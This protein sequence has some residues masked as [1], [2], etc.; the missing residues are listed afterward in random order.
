M[1]PTRWLSRLLVVSLV[2]L[3]VTSTLPAA[4][5]TDATRTGPQFASSAVLEERGDVASIAVRMEDGGSA[6]VDILGKGNSDYEA[7]LTLRDEDNDGRV[8]LEFNTYL[9]GRNGAFETA[10]EGDEVL[11]RGQ[12][13]ASGVLPV[14]SYRMLTDDRNDISDLE[15]EPRETA[16]VTALV[17]PDGA[18]ARLETGDDVARYRR[19]GNLTTRPA[20]DTVPVAERDTLVVRLKASGIAGA[21][22]AQEG[23]NVTERFRSLVASDLLSLDVDW[24]NTGT[25]VPDLPLL[26]NRSGVSVASRPGNDAYFVVVD[27]AA[28]KYRRGEVQTGLPAGAR[29][30]VNATVPAGSALAS[31]GRE[32]ATTTFR[33]VEP[34]ATLRT[35][36]EGDGFYLRQ[37]R[38][39]TVRGRTTLAPGSTV[40]VQVSG[41]DGLQR[42]RTVTVRPSRGLGTFES[43]VDL[44]GV[45][46][47]A[48]I[49]VTATEADGPLTEGPL[50][51]TVR[52][53]GASLDSSTLAADGTTLEVVLE[54]NLTR[55]GLLTV[56]AHNRSGRIVGVT[57]VASGA[58]QASVPLQDLPP[59]DTPLV[60]TAVRDMDGD[61]EFTPG[62]DVPYAQ[63]DNPRPVTLTITLYRLPPSPTPTPS[64]PPTDA[65]PTAT[66]PTPST[67]PTDTSTGP[68][69]DATPGTGGTATPGGGPIPTQVPGFGQV[70]AVLALALVALRRAR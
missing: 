53:P 25:E 24:T 14:G 2:A 67:P 63:S 43:A 19:A 36:R 70:V 66:T 35:H 16:S 55:G 32:T 28:A 48:S 4:V 18:S 69:T 44:R 46:E 47:G 20:N 38:N 57:P 21:L 58:G 56:R 11:V 7:H 62:V 39:Q 64:A 8:V 30:D 65:T 29:F 26:L 50:T 22:A 42:S 37:E 6:D 60:V 52:S 23:D 10:A 5:A 41:P 15:V 12:S 31:D 51:A 3:L 68:P 54:A 1:Q 59:K 34:A 49:E 13:G 40:E 9:A 33:V 17:A 61:G 45:G 27:T